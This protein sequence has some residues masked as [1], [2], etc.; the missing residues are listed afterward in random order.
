MENS[1]NNKK[2]NKKIIF[3]ILRQKAYIKLFKKYSSNKFSYNIICINHIIYNEPC[4]IVSNFKDYLVYDDNGEFITKFYFINDSVIRL[5]KILFLYDKYSK[6]FP[7]YLKLKEREYMYRNI[8]KKQK[9]VDA[10]NQIYEEEEKKK[11]NKEKNNDIDN[12][13]N[14][15]NNKIFTNLVKDEIKSF[16]N[17]ITIRKYKNSFDSE[18][19]KED[20]MNIQSSISISLLNKKYLGNNIENSNNSFNR[21]SIISKKSETNNTLSCLLNIMNDSKLYPNDIQ[22]IFKI[23]QY[24]QISNNLNINNL[25]K[26]NNDNNNIINKK[27]IENKKIKNHL[28]NL[29]ENKRKETNKNKISIE[30]LKKMFTPE[31]KKEDIN[32]GKVKT[33]F[34]TSLFTKKR[35]NP[36][37]NIKY[38]LSNEKP[39]F[40]RKNII[41]SK[42]GEALITN[43]NL[44]SVFQTER[45]DLNK[46]SNN[47]LNNNYKSINYISSKEIENK[48]S[49]NLNKNKLVVNKKKK[50]SNIFAP[51]KNK[52]IS[53]DLS[54]KK[55]SENKYLNNKCK[56]KREFSPQYIH[57]L[58]KRQF[59]SRILSEIYHN[60]N[61]NNNIYDKINSKN[62]YFTK[63]NLK[64]MNNESK[65]KSN[66]T[67]KKDFVKKIVL[68]KTKKSY[69]KDKYKISLKQSEKKDKKINNNSKFISDY[70]LSFINRLKTES[71]SSSKKKQKNKKNGKLHF[72]LIRNKNINTSKHQFSEEKIMSSLSKSK[73]KEKN[74]I[75]KDIKKLISRQ[76]KDNITL[77][78]NLN[79]RANY[80]KVSSYN[81]PSK[82]ISNYNTTN[83]QN[84][85]D[86][87]NINYSTYE[88][89]NKKNILFNS[90]SIDFQKKDFFKH[91]KLSL[92]MNHNKKKDVFNSPLNSLNFLTNEKNKNKIK[93]NN[94]FIYLN[95][96]T[97]LVNPKN[98]P[99][100]FRQ[101][102]KNETNIKYK[103][104]LSKKNNKKSCDLNHEI[105]YQSKKNILNKI[106][107][108]RN[109]SNLFL[110]I[111]DSNNSNSIDYAN[112]NFNNRCYTN[113]NNNTL[114]INTQTKNNEL[115][116]FS[117]QQNKKENINNKN[118]TNVFK[119]IMCNRIKN[120]QNRKKRIYRNNKINTENNLPS[121][122]KVDTS[123]F[124]SN[125]KGK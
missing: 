8:R 5:N 114:N 31:K 118:N 84:S 70:L 99:N 33:N 69:E 2:A 39:F 10:L 1:I 46:K 123:K 80:R 86:S 14:N 25:I 77:Q 121:T 21:K 87:N 30:I 96:K 103:N 89:K 74:K 85:K 92:K 73:N 101:I 53:N 95:E 20:T 106:N 60:R 18:N 110:S 43:S 17:N 105:M 116:Q 34:T 57:G 9:M 47:Y 79:L 83:Y 36:N 75:S 37:L 71:N 58:Q 100:N 15:S 76:I 54:F 107:T 23:N 55:N 35:V 49:Y 68:K 48:K 64:T 122:I 62:N 104:F 63:L 42:L 93:N 111:I 124:L 117:A 44:H 32:M 125:F 59:V 65:A 82:N 45:N 78:Y 22:S 38:N 11:M 28:N 98:S 91:K 40:H 88:N 115:M 27:Y 97:Y 108:I 12:N 29:S 67:N 41:P 52:N 4:Q 50:S 24:S 19:N 3:S 13:N 90:K 72:N 112:F 61:N 56:S 113:Y 120:M 119:K 102:N 16:Q 26:D 6:I 94:K 51:N 81:Y 109:P 7:N 66:I